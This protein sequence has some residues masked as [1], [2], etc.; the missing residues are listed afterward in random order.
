MQIAEYNVTVAE[1]AP[2]P[3]TGISVHYL[4]NWTTLQLILSIT[5]VSR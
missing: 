2:Q 5:W 4:Y 1:S 3:D